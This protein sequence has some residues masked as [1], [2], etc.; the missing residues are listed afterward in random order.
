MLKMF[1]ILTI[2]S[3]VTMN[4]GETVSYVSPYEA[5]TVYKPSIVERAAG[6]EEEIISYTKG[7][8]LIKNDETGEC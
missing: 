2:S 1:M 8:F 4:Q 7:M 3:L 6:K 5:Y